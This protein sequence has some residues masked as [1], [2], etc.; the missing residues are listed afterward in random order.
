MRA[1]KLEQYV[2]ADDET[3]QD[4]CDCLG[5]GEDDEGLPCLTCGGL[6]YF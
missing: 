1:R 5:L 2:S 4:C 3:P 6:G